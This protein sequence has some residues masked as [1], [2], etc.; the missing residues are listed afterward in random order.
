MTDKH[1]GDNTKKGSGERVARNLSV[2]TPKGTEKETAAASVIARNE[3]RVTKQSYSR[4]Q[5]LK[6]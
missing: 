3:E 4:C 1:F 5:I 2:I 6:L